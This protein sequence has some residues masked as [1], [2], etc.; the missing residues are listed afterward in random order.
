MNIIVSSDN[1][2]MLM[3]LHS[4]RF[5]PILQMQPFLK[6]ASNLDEYNVLKKQEMK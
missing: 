6:R 5:C 3:R 1:S 4:G 2:V